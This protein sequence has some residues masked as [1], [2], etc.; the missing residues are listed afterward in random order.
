MSKNSMSWQNS[1]IEIHTT[2]LHTTNNKLFSTQIHI[3]DNA[4]N[5]L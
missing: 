2:E 4:S 1:K 3:F 5:N